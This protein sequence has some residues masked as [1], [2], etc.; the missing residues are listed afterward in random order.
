[1][2]QQESVGRPHELIAGARRLAGG[3]RGA[4]PP[5]APA[6]ARG[7]G[8]HLAMALLGVLLTACGFIGGV[9]VEKGQSSSSSSP[10]GVARRPRLA[11]RRAA[12]RRRRGCRRWRGCRLRRRIFERGRPASARPTA[13]QVAYL[14]GSTLYVTNAEGNTIKVTT[15]PGTSVSK[16]VNASRQ[17]HPPGETVT[18]TGATGA[19]GTVSAESISV[20]SGAS[21]LGGTVRRRGRKRPRRWWRW[22][23]RRRR[24]QQQ[25]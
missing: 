10:T 5:P 21:G 4:A 8:N 2:P 18:V 12:G 14:A 11:L 13:G 19:N 16:T 1:M 15:S 20:G 9:L 24:Q 7:A 3:T 25:W 22:Q 23:S 6:P 17:R